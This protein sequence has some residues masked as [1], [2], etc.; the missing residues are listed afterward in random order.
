M[1]KV[2][3]VLVVILT[4]AGLYAWKGMA[5]PIM[6]SLHTVDQGPVEDTVANTR[7]GTVRACQRSK[8]SMQTGGTVEALM[9]K[10]GDRVE[11][12]QL[13]LQLRDQEYQAA[14]DQA[15]ANLQVVLQKRAEICYGADRDL[16]EQ[17]RQERLAAKKLTSEESLDSA[18]TRAAMSSLACKAAEAQIE[19]AKALV[20]LSEVNLERTRLTAPFAG[21]VAEINGEVGEYVTPSPPGIVTPPAV[22][23]ID[24]K[25]LYVRAPIDEVDTAKI[26]VGMPAKVTLDAFR[27]LSLSARVSRVA[28]YVQDYEKQ[29]RTVDV[30][31]QIDQVPEDL[32][33]LVGYSA[34]IEVIL[35]HHSGVTRIPTEMIMEGNTV[36]R[37]NPESKVLEKQVF[38]PGLSNWVYTE[39]ISGLSPGDR[40]L[41]ALDTEGADEGVVVIP[42]ESTSSQSP[43]L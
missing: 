12:G 35:E 39:I 38:T 19:E 20:K 33:L 34:D 7:A 11:K 17:S 16:R 5:D 41:A 37:F 1:R 6:V 26:K 43:D 8:L 15:K 31:V 25:C 13:L 32:N 36:L 23:L 40:I 24:D 14:L 27:G 18:K 22:D 3:V 10:A 4:A 21:V 28:P 29:A 42:E 30:E 2:I 9:V